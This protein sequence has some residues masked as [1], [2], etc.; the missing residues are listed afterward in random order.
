MASAAPRSTAPSFPFTQFVSPTSIRCRPA[1]GTSGTWA[2]DL[3]RRVALLAGERGEDLLVGRDRVRQRGRQLRLDLVVQLRERGVRDAREDVVFDV[4]VHVQVQEP[5]HRV[6]VD[7]ACAVA[8][9]EHVLA[10]SGVLGDAEEHDQPLAVDAGPADE[11]DRQRCP[12]DEAPHG[13]AGHDADDHAGLPDDLAVLVGG[14]EL[15][16]VGVD[17]SERVAARAGRT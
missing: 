10:Q 11:Q 14:H 13:G 12:G 4:V 1:L 16:R 17:L 15:G 8:V 9:V 6:H 2:V 5:E 7:R 3:V